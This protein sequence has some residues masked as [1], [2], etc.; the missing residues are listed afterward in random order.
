MEEKLLLIL[1]EVTRSG[2][3]GQPLRPRFT[4][5][6]RT[7]K[8]GGPQRRSGSYKKNPLPLTSPRCR[9]RSQTLNLTDLLGLKYLISK[10]LNFYRIMGISC[11]CP[12]ME[13]NLCRYRNEKEKQKNWGGGPGRSQDKTNNHKRNKYIRKLKRQQ[14]K[15]QYS[16]KRYGQEIWNKYL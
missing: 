13:S 7:R 3:I 6:E 2:V 1:H 5:G 16:V 11:L 14:L 12:Y 8:M 4:P 9:D 10:L 15:K